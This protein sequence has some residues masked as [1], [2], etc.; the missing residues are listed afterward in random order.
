MKREKIYGILSLQSVKMYDKILLYFGRRGQAM[1]PLKT[2]E[3]IY[4]RKKIKE[5]IIKK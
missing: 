2:I 5:D 1:K 3:E 4:K